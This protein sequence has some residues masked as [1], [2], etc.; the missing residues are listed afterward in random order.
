MQI[1]A[2]IRKLNKHYLKTVDLVSFSGVKVKWVDWGAAKSAFPVAFCSAKV[3][4]TTA[5]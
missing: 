2:A 5:G 1:F 4:R 3:K